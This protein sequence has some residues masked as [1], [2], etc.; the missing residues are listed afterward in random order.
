VECG[1][2]AVIHAITVGAANGAR[3]FAYIAKC[4]RN[5]IPPAP[6]VTPN[7]VVELPGV[8]RFE[9]TPT[10]PAPTTSPPTPLP[11]EHD[12]WQT[13]MGDLCRGL[14]ADSPAHGWLEGSRLVE[15]ADVAGVPLYQVVI[16]DPDGVG[17]LTNR[18]GVL[19]RRSLSVVLHKRIL[20]EVVCVES[21]LANERGVG[22]G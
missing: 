2:D 18:M 5:Y 11:K 21:E 15:A 22:N 17:W 3:N 14:P 19:F 16:R 12:P 7:Y 4:A 9:P 8:H 10:P 20:V 6:E 1:R 13:V